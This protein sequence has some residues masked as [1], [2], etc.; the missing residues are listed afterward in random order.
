MRIVLRVLRT[1]RVTNYKT[2][3]CVPKTTDDY[4]T[5][6]RVS[7]HQKHS[8][9]YSIFMKMFCSLQM[10]KLDQAIEDCS[11]AI[12]LDNGY[13]KAFMRRAKW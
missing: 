13:I 1:F 3:Y 10:K 8:L 2:F 12:E 4:F 9:V 7:H 5:A 6:V 11:K